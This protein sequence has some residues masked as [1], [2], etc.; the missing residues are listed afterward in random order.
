[1][2]F[3]EPTVVYSRKC[4]FI[5]ELFCKVTERIC[6]KGPGKEPANPLIYKMFV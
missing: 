3:T 5:K 2:K 1:M 4:V 6:S